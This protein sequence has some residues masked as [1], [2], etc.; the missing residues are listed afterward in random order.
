M[1][2]VRMYPYITDKPPYIS[3]TSNRLI[4]ILNLFNHLLIVSLTPVTLISLNPVNLYV[5]GKNEPRKEV[6]KRKEQG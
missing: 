1:R 3:T 4:K 5:I 2:K 6:T